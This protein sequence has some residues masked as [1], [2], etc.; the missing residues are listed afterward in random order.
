MTS[1]LG[2]IDNDTGLD[3]LPMPVSNVVVGSDEGI[4]ALN[5]IDETSPCDGTHDGALSFDEL[6]GRSEGIVLGAVD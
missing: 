3:V 2:I 5:G 4:L 6:D 1:L